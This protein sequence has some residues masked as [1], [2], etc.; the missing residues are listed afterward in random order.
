MSKLLAIAFGALALLLALSCTPSPQPSP[1]GTFAPSP[2]LHAT[3]TPVSTPTPSPSPQAATT[4]PPTPTTTPT[5]APAG[6]Y[7]TDAPDRDLFSLVQRLRP[8]S[9]QPIARVVNPEPVS[10]AVGRQDV[11]WVADLVDMKMY[12]VEAELL[13]VSEH[14]YWY[15]QKGFKPPVETLKAAAQ[16]F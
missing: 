12:R 13:F 7:L 1:T 16:T 15:F 14:A 3:P 4:P 6:T 11:F 8:N 9:Q 5:P 10:Y 2:T